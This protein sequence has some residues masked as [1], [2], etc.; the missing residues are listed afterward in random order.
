[1]SLGTSTWTQAINSLCSGAEF[2]CWAALKMNRDRYIQA[3]A[4]SLLSYSQ[5]AIQGAFKAKH[6]HLL[7]TVREQGQA[8]KMIVLNSGIRLI[9]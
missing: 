5:K 3:A 4:D 2:A 1:M 8:V 7:P 6:D 9:R